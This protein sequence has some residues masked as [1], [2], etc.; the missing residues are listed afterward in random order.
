MYEIIIEKF[1]I[2]VA[3]GI[4]GALVGLIIYASKM[5]W[6]AWLS[7][8]ERKI[9]E[10][11]EMIP[12]LVKRDIGVY[13]DLTELLVAVGADRAFVMQFHNGTYYVNKG[14]QMKMSCTHEIVREGIS[15]EQEDMQD[16]LLSRFPSTVN[17]LLSS[18]YTSVSTK[19]Q[20]YFFAQMLKNQGV[21]RCIMAV[22]KDGE[23]VEGFLGV[24]FLAD[25]NV[26]EEEVGKLVI[27]YSQRIGYTLRK[28]DDSE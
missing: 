15:R 25:E 18:P 1:G 13:R 20:S 9:T 7:H 28:K 14:N 19:D 27:D 12:R 23:I 24:S 16:I 2:E 3:T 8:K 5:A 26:N 4:G 11:K 22:I 10:E 21:N 17:D 6:N